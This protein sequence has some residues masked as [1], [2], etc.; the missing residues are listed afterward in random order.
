MKI[1][2]IDD[3][4]NHQDAAK[5]QLS[6][7]ETT[8]VG[9]YS[10]GCKLLV[11]KHEFEVVLVDLLMPPSDWWQKKGFTGGDMPFGIFLALLAAKNG[12]KYVAVFTDSN[13]HDHPASACL[14]DFNEHETCPTPFTVE[15]ATVLFCNNRNWVNYFRPDNLAEKVDSGPSVRA[16]NW[17]KVFE[18]LTA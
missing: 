6:G 12:A 2:V 17:S 5:A 16:K 8:V 13:H 15:G 1:L 14:D 7:H 18:Y 3:S 11:K 4:K 9:S 10:D